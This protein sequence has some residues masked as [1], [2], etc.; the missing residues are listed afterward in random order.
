MAISREP[1]SGLPALTVCHLATWPARGRA[2]GPR[3]PRR[4]RRPL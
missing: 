3:R 2:P 4:Q 1:V